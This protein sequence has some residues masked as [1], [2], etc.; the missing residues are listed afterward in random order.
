MTGEE[1]DARWWVIFNDLVW[2]QDHREDE[3]TAAIASLECEEQFGP[4][5]EDVAS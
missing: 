1:W 2:E 3:A 4:R 5:P